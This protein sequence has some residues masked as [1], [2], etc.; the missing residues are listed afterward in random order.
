[1]IVFALGIVIL[2]FV[3]YAAYQ[4]FALPAAALFHANG[5]T[6]GPLT[7]VGLG[8]VIAWILV[9]IVLLFVMTLAGSIIASKGIQ[10]YLGCSSAQASREPVKIE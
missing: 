4:M 6:G 3:L 9:R 7:A 5:S 8:T 10:L 1:M 2:F